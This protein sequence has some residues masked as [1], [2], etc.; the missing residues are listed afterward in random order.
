MHTHSTGPSFRSDYC[1][2]MIPFGKFF[3][4]TA[5]STGIQGIWIFPK[6]LPVT[7]HIIYFIINNSIELTN[8]FYRVLVETVMINVYQ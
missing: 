8:N 4:N 3:N 6:Y 5:H 1:P 2:Y 7:I